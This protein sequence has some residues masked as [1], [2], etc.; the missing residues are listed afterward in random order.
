MSSTSPRA[1]G[2]SHAP[3]AH[4]S[5][6][7]DF[8]SALSAPNDNWLETRMRKH[9]SYANLNPD[10]S[11]GYSLPAVSVDGARASSR[12]SHSSGTGSKRSSSKK[13]NANSSSVSAQPS[14]RL[15]YTEKARALLDAKPEQTTDERSL[16]APRRRNSQQQHSSHVGQVRENHVVNKTFTWTGSAKRSVFLAGTF[17]SW[18]MPV[19]M[20]KY[21]TVKRNGRTI[22]NWQCVLKLRPSTYKFKF[23]VDGEWQVDRSSEVVPCQKYGAVN[24]LSV[25]HSAH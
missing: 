21:G 12:S 8:S 15:V 14:P 11:T 19:P 5:F 23:V 22:D 17:N 4:P 13:S 16:A 24:V 6:S 2:R 20:Y 9:H 1:S 7:S 10:L 18:G 25:K 3:F